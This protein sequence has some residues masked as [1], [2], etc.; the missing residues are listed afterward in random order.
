MLH[1]L[2]I[3]RTIKAGPIGFF[4]LSSLLEKK[5]NIL[6]VDVSRNLQDVSQVFLLGIPGLTRERVY[7][8]INSCVL[9]SDHCD[10]PAACRDSQNRN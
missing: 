6:T 4:S 7:M 2:R 1:A 8:E 10:C 9:R 5:L 3:L